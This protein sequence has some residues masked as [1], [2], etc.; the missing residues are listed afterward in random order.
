[1]TRLARTERA[2]L[3]DTALEVGEDQPTLSGEW[4]VKDLVVH[5]LV[6]E[7]SPASIGTVVSP[8]AGLTAAA[9]RRLG[10]RP[11]PELVA[12]LRSG[13]P[14]LSPFA[15]PKIDELANTAEY[16]IHHEDVRRA[17]PGWSP[18]PPD[19]ERDRQ[20]WRMVGLL[21]RLSYR[22]SPVAVTL[23]RPDGEEHAVRSGPRTVILTGEPGELLLHA[24]GREECVVHPEG[25]PADVAAVMALD[26]GL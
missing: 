10:R 25:E 24:A 7:G 1:M 14:R 8:L 23:R 18:R 22:A 26:R 5:L 9:S 21:G 6:R 19:E 4:T 20:I 16:F 17:R 13:P 12:R 15:I 2:A 11:F 3:C